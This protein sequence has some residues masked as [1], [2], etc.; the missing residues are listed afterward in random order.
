MKLTINNLFSFIAYITPFLVTFY[1]ITIGLMQ[2]GSGG[3]VKSMI[4]S[5]GILLVLIIATMLQN[6]IAERGEMPSHPLCNLFEIPFIDNAYVN[7]AISTT[8]ITFSL[9]Y[10]LFPMISSGDYKF[11]LLGFMSLLLLLNVVT[12]YSKKCSSF[13]GVV[14]G[15]I[16]GMSIAG[17]YTWGVSFDT[18]S[19]LL[20]FGNQVSNNVTCSKPTNQTFKC[21]VYKNGKVIQNL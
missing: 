3:A 5:A 11:A 4:Y 10:L 15:L 19:D 20:F 12:Q 21:A 9:F 1:I 16:T 8:V 14:S 18:D 13:M 6:S 2:G 17:L 7:P